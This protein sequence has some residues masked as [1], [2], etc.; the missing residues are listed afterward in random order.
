M[1]ALIL[2]ALSTIMVTSNA[3]NCKGYTNTTCDTC[4]KAGCT[5]CYNGDECQPDS[6]LCPSGST[7]SGST[8]NVTAIAGA[9]I[10]VIV[11]AIICC[12]LF[13]CGCCICWHRGIYFFDEASP[14]GYG[15]RYRRKRYE[16]GTGY[17]QQRGYYNQSQGATLIVVDDTIEHHH[18]GH[19]HHHGSPHNHHGNGHGHGRGGYGA[20]HH[21]IDM[22]QIDRF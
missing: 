20:T 8:C 22:H 4:V 18:H 1:S 19:G 5:W 12:C 10:A 6:S 17:D 13:C 2:L 7:I 3:Q 9:V 15:A 16:Y 11:I 21:Q 14:Y